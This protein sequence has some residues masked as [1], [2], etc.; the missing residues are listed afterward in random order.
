MRKKVQKPN[1]CILWL[2]KSGEGV[3]DPIFQTLGSTIHWINRYPADKYYGN[4]LRYQL[5]G[6]LSGGEHYPSLNN[7]GLVLWI[8]PSMHL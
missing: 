2:W 3:L 7:Q 6:D 5:D 1:K 4:Q 8:I